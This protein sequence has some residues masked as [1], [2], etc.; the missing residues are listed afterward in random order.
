MGPGNGVLADILNRLYLLTGKSA[1]RER[2]AAVIAAFSSQL[3]KNFFPLA[4]L[5]NA[6]ECMARPLQVVVVGAADARNHPAARIDRGFRFI[7]VEN[8]FASRS[9]R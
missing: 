7:A 5:I 6:A 9:A 3:A 1:Y 8:D 4:T 2:A